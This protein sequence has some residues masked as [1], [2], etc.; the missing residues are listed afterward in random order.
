[1]DVVELKAY[2]GYGISKI[3]ETDET[4]NRKMN[5]PVY[6]ADDGE[7][8][9]GDEYNTLKEVKSFIDTL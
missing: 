4:G 6:V 8:Y 3:Y 5:P 9:I 2:K 1:M 7:D